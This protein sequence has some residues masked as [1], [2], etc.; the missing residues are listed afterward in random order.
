MITGLGKRTIAGLTFCYRRSE[1]IIIII[2]RDGWGFIIRPFLLDRKEANDIHEIT[3]ISVFARSRKPP[4]NYLV[5]RNL[6]TKVRS[7]ITTIALN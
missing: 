3:G 5:K 7:V 1:T 6:N 4:L 2:T